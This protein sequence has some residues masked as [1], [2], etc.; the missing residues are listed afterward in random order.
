[1]IVS[2]ILFIIIFLVIVVSHEF[3]HYIVGKKNGIHANEF[4]VGMGPKLIKWNKDNTEFSIRLLP[5]GGACVFEG[6]DELEN[7]NSSEGEAKFSEH[8]FLNA[9]VWA[10]FATTLAGPMFNII[11]AYVCG[12]ILASVTGVVIPEI[13]TVLEDSAAEEVG[14]MPGDII[15]RINGHSVHLSSEVSFDSYYSTGRDMTVTVLRDGQKKM[16]VLTPKYS[17]EDERY[18]MGIT[19]GRYIEC[20]LLDSLKYGFYNVQYIL[21]ATVEGIRMLFTG[22]VGKDELA[23]PVGIVQVVDDTYQESRAYGFLSVLLS[24]INITMLLSANLAVMNLIP[25]PGLDGGR[26]LFSI[27]EI[28]TKK[29]VPPEKEGYVTLAGMA[30]LMALVVFVLFNDI[31]KFFR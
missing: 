2:I 19:N 12:V 24:M 28:I 4:F 8:S 17:E 21:R 14:L 26:L 10:R 18:Y 3:G 20:G 5:F 7:A 9:N 11:L 15:L 6:M 31:S 1:M 22:Q 27:I 16:F 23:G 30:L 13:Q 25:I 29:R